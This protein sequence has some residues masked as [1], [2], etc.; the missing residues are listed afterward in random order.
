MQS[1]PSATAGPLCVDA[2]DLSR[3]HEMCFQATTGSRCG[4]EISSKLEFSSDAHHG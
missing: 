4:P 1:P 2:P 3:P